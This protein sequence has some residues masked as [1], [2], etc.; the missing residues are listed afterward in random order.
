MHLCIRDILRCSAQTGSVI[1]K[2]I[3][4]V[5]KQDKLVSSKLV[6]GRAQS[7]L[8]LIEQSSRQMPT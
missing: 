6:D 5:I 3:D 1:G 4:A 8:N 2:W 7:K